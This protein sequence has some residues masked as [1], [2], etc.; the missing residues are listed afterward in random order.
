MVVVLLVAVLPPLAVV[1]CLVAAVATLLVVMVPPVVVDYCLSVVAAALLLLLLLPLVPT[2][3]PFPTA[4]T[5]G[6]DPLRGL[7]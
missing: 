5:L 7:P 2:H 1:M 3:G 4:V 6:T